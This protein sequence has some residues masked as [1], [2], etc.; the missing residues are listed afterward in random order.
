MSAIYCT[1]GFLYRQSFSR[2]AWAS[3]VAYGTLFAT[4]CRDHEFEEVAE[5]CVIGSEIAAGFDYQPNHPVGV[6]IRFAECVNDCERIISARCIAS[7]E[8]MNVDVSGRLTLR[9]TAGCDHSCGFVYA[10]CDSVELDEG[11]YVFAADFLEVVVPIPSQS[12]KPYC[13]PLRDEE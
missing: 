5:I 10:T 6:E 7:V 2:L 13:H 3:F 4:S 1:I 8:G 12:P 9:T 11:E